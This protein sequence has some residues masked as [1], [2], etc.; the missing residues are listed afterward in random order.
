MREDSPAPAT[1]QART[2]TSTATAL[3]IISG[4]QSIIRFVPPAEGWSTD[5]RLPGGRFARYSSDPTTGIWRAVGSYPREFVSPLALQRITVGRNWIEV[6]LTH[7]QTGNVWSFDGDLDNVA[8]LLWR[9]GQRY[10]CQAGRKS[11]Y[12]ALREFCAA[13]QRQAAA[14]G[15]AQ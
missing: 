4:G 14:R 10:G 13:V 2:D 15:V 11:I 9:T 12:W 5:A 3:M 1:G 7:P 8:T 6:E